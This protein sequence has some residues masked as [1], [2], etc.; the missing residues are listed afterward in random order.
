MSSGPGTVRTGTSVG[1]GAVVWVGV[2]VEASLAWMVGPVEAS[3]APVGVAEHA[4]V[5]YRT[6]RTSDAMGR[7]VGRPSPQLTSML[8]D[9]R[10]PQTRARG[11][12]E[13]RPRQSPGR[14]R[15]AA[16]S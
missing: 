10:A 15:L 9:R 3:G 8:P 7:C 12:F 11:H 5:P 16:A 2:I 1:V 13:G 14:S 6:A 4:A